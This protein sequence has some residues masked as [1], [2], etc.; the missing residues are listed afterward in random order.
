MNKE[1]IYEFKLH[2]NIFVNDKQLRDKENQRV[3]VLYKLYKM[4][5]KVFVFSFFT[6][7]FHAM[8]G[9]KKYGISYVHSK[10]LCVGQ[11]R[12]RGLVVLLSTKSKD[13]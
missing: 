6:N 5:L 11:A 8:Q 10:Q 4:Q 2:Y 1:Q 12:Y 13:P 3:V 9:C 7:F